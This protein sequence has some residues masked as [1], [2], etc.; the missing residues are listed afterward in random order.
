MTRLGDVLSAAVDEAGVEIDEVAFTFRP[1]TR[2]TLQ[3]EAI[4]DAVD[5]ARKKAAAA[6]EVEGLTV[7]GVRSIVT[8]EQNRIR[9]TSA[10]MRSGATAESGSVESGPIDVAVR[11]EVEYCLS[12][13]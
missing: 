8:D 1:E 3:R 2:R 7:D 12:D 10:A 4:A 9:R 5:E 6:A 13:S 11:V